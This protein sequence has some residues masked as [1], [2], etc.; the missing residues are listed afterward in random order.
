MVETDEKT[1]EEG[2][3][4]EQRIF[5]V[6]EVV[7]EREQLVVFADVEDQ[8]D[9]LPTKSPPEWSDE[10]VSLCGWKQEDV[11]GVIEGE[12]RSCA[13]QNEDSDVPVLFQWQKD[14]AA[15]E[16]RLKERK[17]EEAAEM[18]KKQA[19]LMGGGLVKDNDS[20]EEEWTP[21]GSAYRKKRKDLTARSSQKQHG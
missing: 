7:R 11:M 3:A 9:L 18:W 16:E 14:Q 10:V 2:V 4:K 19:M 12:M 1:L 15:R 13:H 20:N 17:A 8:Q 21:E 5:Q 6:V